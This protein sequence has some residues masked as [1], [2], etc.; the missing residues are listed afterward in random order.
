M[1][2]RFIDICSF[3]IQGFLPTA[4]ILRLHGLVKLSIQL[5]S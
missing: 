5:E 4:Q 3:R 2:I 1:L